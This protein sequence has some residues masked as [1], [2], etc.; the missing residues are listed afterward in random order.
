V[1]TTGGVVRLLEVEPTKEERYAHALALLAKLTP[2][3]AATTS[4]KTTV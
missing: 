2:K 3:P 1:A 4:Q